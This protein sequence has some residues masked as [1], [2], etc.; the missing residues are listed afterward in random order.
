MVGLQYRKHKSEQEG[1]ASHIWAAIWDMSHFLS[2]F[3]LL[4]HKCSHHVGIK[5]NESA[6]EYNTDGPPLEFIRDLNALV[7]NGKVAKAPP[8]PPQPAASPTGMCVLRSGRIWPDYHF[9]LLTVGF[10]WCHKTRRNRFNPAAGP[11]S[12]E[13]D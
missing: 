11:P 12:E 8:P 3:L 13:K 10:C 2:F 6:P 4:T 1:A 9:N 7:A 5:G